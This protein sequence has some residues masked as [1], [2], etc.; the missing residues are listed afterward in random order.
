MP[1][2]RLAASSQLSGLVRVIKR[3]NDRVA[4][5][6]DDGDRTKHALAQGR[7]VTSWLRSL[8]SPLAGLFGFAPRSD[9]GAKT[10]HE[11]ERLARIAAIVLH[12]QPGERL[13][14]VNGLLCVVIGCGTHG[15]NVAGELLRRGCFVRL[16]DAL[17]VEHALASIRETLEQ[18]VHAQLLLARDVQALLARCTAAPSLEDALERDPAH[19]G[20]TLVIE[21]VPD[22]VDVKKLVFCEVVDACTRG[23]IPPQDVLLC[24]NTLACPLAELAASLPPSYGG[25]LVGMRFLHPCWFVDAVDLYMIPVG[26]DPSAAALAAEQETAEAFARIVKILGL[27]RA[28]RDRSLTSEEATLS[29]VRQLVRVEADA[30]TAFAEACIRV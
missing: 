24:S 2:R 28:E 12:P 6:E 8:R 21:A 16:Y 3:Q 29:A 19:V 30:T 18:L 13:R 20:P 15:R 11:D 25:R 14:P 9:D 26:P 23:G 5:L 10:D 4:L 27:A 1:A 22:F 7:R 17:L